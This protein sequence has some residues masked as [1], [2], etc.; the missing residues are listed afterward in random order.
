MVSCDMNSRLHLH[1]S[2][3]AGLPPN[4]HVSAPCLNA[5]MN[6]VRYFLRGIAMLACLQAVETEGLGYLQIRYL[7]EGSRVHQTEM[8]W[9]RLKMQH[10]HEHEMS[11]LKQRHDMFEKDSKQAMDDLMCAS[12]CH[13]H[14]PYGP[15]C[16]PDVLWGLSLV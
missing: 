2:C 4:A 10:K 7:E 6:Q 14:V 11:V 1:L 13:M 9:L 3:D 8:E 5:T 12:E 16:G 15:A